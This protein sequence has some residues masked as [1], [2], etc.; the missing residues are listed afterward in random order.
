MVVM[1]ALVSCVSQIQKLEPGWDGTS[2]PQCTESWAPV[3]GDGV[4][5]VVAGAFGAA[6]AADP[7]QSDKTTSIAI[8]GLGVGLVF[9]IAAAIGEGE[10]RDCR[11]AKAQ[12]RVGGAIGARAGEVQAAT[13]R[14]AE[15]QPRVAPTPP[16]TPRG[17]FCASSPTALVA[18]GCTRQ[19]A[20]CEQIRDG[21]AAGVADVSMCALVE[22]AWCFRLSDDGL[23]KCASSADACDARRAMVTGSPPGQCEERQ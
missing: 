6:A 1:C 5:G 11:I 22:S 15:S 21:I 9:S 2:E 13:I 18:S 12:W 4:I 17:F 20:S 19:R 8:V 14:A 23:W 7:I 10:V 3:V 16:P